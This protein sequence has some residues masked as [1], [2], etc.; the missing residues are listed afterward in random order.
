MMYSNL[1]RIKDGY[2]NTY[3]RDGTVSFWDVYQQR[4]VRLLAARISDQVLST[5]SESA[6][7]RIRDAR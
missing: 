2:R 1:P 3:H 5:F 7:R 6:R 4:W